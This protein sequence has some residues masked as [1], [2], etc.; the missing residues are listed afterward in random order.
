MHTKLVW[1]I[2]IGL[3]LSKR[4]YHI[5]THR[6]SSI[7]SYKFTTSFTALQHSLHLVLHQVRPCPRKVAVKHLF[8]IIAE[9]ATIYPLKQRAKMG[10]F[11]HKIERDRPFPPRLLATYLNEK[12]EKSHKIE[13]QRPRL[14]SAPSRGNMPFIKKWL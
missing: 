10:R 7:T 1:I 3:G 2:S 13:K 14:S 8:D 9:E 6:R 4:R 5:T 11:P 12:R